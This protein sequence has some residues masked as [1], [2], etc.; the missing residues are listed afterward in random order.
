MYLLYEST[1]LFL[2]I[3]TQKKRRYLFTE[4]LY[5]S[6]HSNPNPEDPHWKQTKCPST[7]E[8]I[9]KCGSFIQ[10][11]TESKSI[12]RIIAVTQNSHLRISKKYVVWSKSDTKGYITVWFIYVK[13]SNWQ[14]QIYSDVNLKLLPLE[15]RRSRLERE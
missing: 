9:N 1:F 3:F 6:L 15:N 11:N 2:K 12:K 5:K 8:Y 7:S 10:W 13:S 14:K 4:N